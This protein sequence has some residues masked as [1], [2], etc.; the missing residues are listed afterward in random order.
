M[1]EPPKKATGATPAGAAQPVV[2]AD[3]FAAIPR[4]R[5][6]HPVLALGAGVLALFLVVKM[7]ADLE[8]FLSPRVPADLGE[9]RALLSS[10]RGRA[11]LAE[12]TNRLVRIHGIPDRESALQ[13]DT[14]GSWTFTQFFKI[15]GSDS[16]LFI[17]RR[18]D[19][20]PASRAEVDIFEGRLLRFSDLSFEDAIRA[21]FASHVSA[22]HFFGERDLAS[23]ITAAGDR[24]MDLRDLAGDTVTLG[25][26]DVL[27][28]V[29]R[30]PGEVEVS[31]PV[32]RYADAASA[33]DALTARGATVIASGPS[34]ADHHLFIATVPQ[35]SR[36]R[37]L[38]EIGDLDW[39]VAIHE[40]RETLTV[41][42]GELTAVGGKL[43]LRGSAAGPSGAPIPGPRLLANIETIRTLAPVQIP[44]DA[45]LIVEAETPREHLPDVAIALVLLV[46][47]S[48][49]LVGLAKGLRT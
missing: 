33:R 47:A 8:Y 10:E 16:R 34:S 29:V 14:K 36:D 38:D 11:V 9:A 31:L 18:E 22:T 46:F 1:D 30:H 12:G 49:N 4:S 23:G 39:R 32:V 44:A 13:V 27:A 40:V 25:P 19:P 24:A 20:L 48:V 45:Y 3:E 43:A 21:Y 26:N 15:L 17:H 28:V 37:V 6:R 35:P 7:R 5:T 2:D 41:R 42:L